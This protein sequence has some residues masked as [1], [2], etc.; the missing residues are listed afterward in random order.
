MPIRNQSLKPE[1]NFDLIKVRIRADKK[2][3]DATGNVVSLRIYETLNGLTT[4]LMVITDPIGI[5]DVL[6]MKGRESI[7]LEFCSYSGENPH[8]K[9]KKTFRVESF[10]RMTSSTAGSEMIEIR[11]VNQSIIENNHTKKSQAFKNKSSSESV[12]MILDSFSCLKDYKFDIED[13]LYQRTFTASL[14]RPFDIIKKLA[15]HS[16][17]KSSGSCKYMFYENSK[18]I[19]FKSLGTLIKQT[20]TYMLVNE[21]QTSK[22]YNAG[23]SKRIIANRISTPTGAN[24][25]QSSKR[26]EIGSRVY[27]HSLINKT[28][29]IHDMTKQKF[30]S[31]DTSMNS[32]E[33]DE[34]DLASSDQPFNAVMVMPGDG[35]YE[36]DA[37]TSNG[38][39]TAIRMMEETKMNKTVMAEIPGNTDITVGD[40]VYLNH[41]S[42]KDAKASANGSG[43]WLIS[44]VCHS[45]TVNTFMT[46][47]ELISD[48]TDKTKVQ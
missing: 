44:K 14:Q 43:K 26:A 35:F 2:Y 28:I 10:S 12:K 34:P 27:T 7:D 36:S 21:A 47:L 3:A 20:P 46:E 38:H 45:L 33:Y 24:A 11:F 8:P 25:L 48:S 18:G 40:V 23:R 6:N 42:M 30:N 37:K 9:Y 19:C 16:V 31:F 17:S 15:L 4:G 5:I 13:T 32:D 1:N 39:V 22:T 29:T 41:I